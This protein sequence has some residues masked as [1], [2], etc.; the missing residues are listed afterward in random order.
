MHVEFAVPSPSDSSTDYHQLDMASGQTPPCSMDANDPSSMHA[1][2]TSQAHP[3]RSTRRNNTFNGAPN[4]EEQRNIISL[5]YRADRYASLHAIGP[6]KDVGLLH[7]GVTKK[8]FLV[9]KKCIF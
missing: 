5:R 1:P 7:G 2:A 9:T 8:H 6:V 4:E 3:H